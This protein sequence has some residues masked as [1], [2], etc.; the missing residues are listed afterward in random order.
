MGENRTD[1]DAGEN[2]GAGT[3]ARPSATGVQRMLFKTPFNH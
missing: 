1:R 3:L 2:L